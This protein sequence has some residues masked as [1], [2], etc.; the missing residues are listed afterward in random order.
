MGPRKTKIHRLLMDII[1]SLDFN[2]HLDSYPYDMPLR[3][4]RRGR[5]GK[6]GA[7]LNLDGCEQ[8]LWLTTCSHCLHLT[9]VRQSH[10][11]PNNIHRKSTL[12]IHGSNST[13]S[14][15]AELKLV[16]A[17]ASAARIFSIRDLTV[18]QPM[19]VCTCTL[20]KLL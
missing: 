12:S 9:S 16:F 18:A 19:H 8:G 14:A 10:S 20:Y 7:E 4:G 15:F 5:E 11:R 13:T 3:T 1:I 6:R 2:G 17:S